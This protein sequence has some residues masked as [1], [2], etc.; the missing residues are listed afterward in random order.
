MVEAFPLRA[1]HP[2]V[3]LFYV[4]PTNPSGAISTSVL[5]GF[6]CV[7]DRALAF[8]DNFGRHPGALASAVSPAPAHSITGVEVSWSLAVAGQALHR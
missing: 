2:G 6:H 4:Q 3:R 1:G 5:V 7:T 8:L